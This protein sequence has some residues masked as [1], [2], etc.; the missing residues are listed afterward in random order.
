[1]VLEIS[2]LSLSQELVPI[3]TG[4]GRAKGVFPGTTMMLKVL[5]IFWL[6]LPFHQAINLY[7]GSGAKTTVTDCVIFKIFCPKPYQW[8]CFL[9]QKPWLW[10]CYLCVLECQYFYEKVRVKCLRYLGSASKYYSTV[11]YYIVGW[12]SAFVANIPWFTSQLQL[13]VAIKD[14]ANQ[15]TSLSYLVK[16]DSFNYSLIL[17]ILLSDP[18]NSFFSNATKISLSLHYSKRPYLSSHPSLHQFLKWN[19]IFV[20]PSPLLPSATIFRKL[21]GTRDAGRKKTPPVSLKQFLSR[22]PKLLQCLAMPD[23]RS[24]TS[25]Y[26][27]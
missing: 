23:H 26:F 10:L 5:P 25:S 19:S 18:L 6:Y 24:S 15:L 9:N 21:N 27:L 22:F 20:P 11:K 17:L 2:S 7:L 14:A 13:L 4:I 8:L 12:K 1:M 16:D 3:F